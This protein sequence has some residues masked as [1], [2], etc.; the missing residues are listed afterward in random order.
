MKAF[1]DIKYLFFSIEHEN[2]NNST[3]VQ[4]L[5]EI[6]QKFGDDQYN[7]GV[8]DG[9]TKSIILLQEKRADL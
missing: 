5:M 7:W 1:E 3:K 2:M 6:L 4:T 8:K 9:M